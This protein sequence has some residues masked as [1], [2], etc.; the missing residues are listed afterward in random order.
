MKRASID[1]IVR[2]YLFDN[3]L[4]IHYYAECLS[5]ALRCARELAYDTVPTIKSVRLET[6]EFAEATL[7]T[8]FVDWI[9]IGVEFG[10]YIV[11][12]VY[13]PSINLLEK[14]ASDGTTQIS[15][16]DEETLY[17]EDS[18]LEYWD[19]N[20]NWGNGYVSY[21]YGAGVEQDI[22]TI[23]PDRNVI[24]LYSGLTNGTTIHLRYLGFDEAT[25]TS[26]IDK[27]AEETVSAYIDW[28]RSERRPDIA[29]SRK[30]RLENRYYN[31]H[32]KL[33]ARLNPMGVEEILRIAR[34]NFKQSP[35]T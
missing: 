12:L 8:D 5:Y 10:Q 32:R 13:R 31:E 34:R 26:T 18:L 4:P 17:N 14:Y 23:A 9:K 11:P 16:T 3:G 24:Q 21:G 1:S 25:A 2:G 6:N 29:E 22:F 33:R 27:Y 20:F 7:P 19:Y 35:K 30:Q 15:Y 28:K